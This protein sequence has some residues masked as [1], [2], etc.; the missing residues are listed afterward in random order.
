MS[1]VKNI[2]TINSDGQLLMTEVDDDTPD[3]L[4]NPAINYSLF[5]TEKYIEYCKKTNRAFDLYSSKGC[6]FDCT[7]CY[8]ISKKKVRYRS[9][10]IIAEE[11]NYLKKTHGIN[12]FCFVDDNFGV[13]KKWLSSF[14]EFAANNDIKYCIQS[15][16]H[17]LWDKKK[18]SDLKRTGLYSIT[19]GVESGSPQILKEMQKQISLDKASDVMKWCRELGIA[20]YG[21]FILGYPSENDETINQTS[22]FLIKNGFKTNFNLNFLALY[23]KTGIY[24]HAINNGLLMDEKKYLKNIGLR[25]EL[26]VNL[27]K[28]PDK[29]LYSW[30]DKILKE[31]AQ[32]HGMAYTDPGLNSLRIKNIG[33]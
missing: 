12:R 10:E 3:I 23:P 9:L 21:S 18:L 32:Y 30:R 24:Q 6:P 17:L 16:I 1:Y 29:T 31:I 28:F 26:V 13:N 19:I 22:Q 5:P 8:K 14:L 2:K 11:I 15:S 7:F 27:T 4:E 20:Y 25:N 33:E